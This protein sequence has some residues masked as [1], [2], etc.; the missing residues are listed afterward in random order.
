MPTIVGFVES[1]CPFPVGF[2]G[3]FQN[4]PNTIYAGTTWEQKKDGFLLTAGYSYSAWEY[5]CGENASFTLTEQTKVRY[6]ITGH[7][8]EKTLDAGTYKAGNALFGDPASGASKHV[9]KLIVKKTIEAGST[10][11]EA[12]TDNPLKYAT[13]TTGVIPYLAMPFWIR[14]A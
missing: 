4:D 3:F 1:G 9:D 7:Y 2:G 8:V 10:S 12:E 5:V 6:G 13:A 11:A 14:T